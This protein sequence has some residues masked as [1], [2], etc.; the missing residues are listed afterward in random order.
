MLST[1]SRFQKLSDILQV[2]NVLK[3]KIVDYTYINLDHGI[4]IV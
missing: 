2:C 1:M 4:C 3:G